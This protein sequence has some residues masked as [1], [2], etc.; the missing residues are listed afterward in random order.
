MR[1]YDLGFGCLGNGITVYNRNRMCGGD[2]QTV[3]H[4]APCGA[5]KLY[6]PL[7]GEARAQIIRQA[8]NAAK[9]FRQTWAETGRMRR[10]EE[11]SE[12]IM[13][14]A[15]FKAFGGYDTLLALTTEQSLALFI[16]YTCINKGYINPNEPETF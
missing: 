15:Q 13:T 3:A 1:T 8:R 11:L 7:P 12:H 9:A 2:Y 6:I 10:L 4:I 14:Y 5:Y 16:Q